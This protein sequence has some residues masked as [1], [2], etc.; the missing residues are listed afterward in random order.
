MSFKKKNIPC[1]SSN[2]PLN[3]F[4]FASLLKTKGLT[5]KEFLNRNEKYLFLV[6]LFKNKI[7]ALNP[8]LFISPIYSE[9]KGNKWLLRSDEKITMSETRQKGIKQRG[10]SDEQHRRKSRQWCAGMGM[11]ALQRE[12]REC[13]KPSSQSRP[14][15]GYQPEDENH[16]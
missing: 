7:D 14:C 3:N 4:Q 13:V 12:G 8:T 6:G 16:L 2:W 1:K 5:K 15:L 11:A 10:E 9:A